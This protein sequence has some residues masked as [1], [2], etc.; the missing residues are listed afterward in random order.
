MLMNKEVNCSNFRGLLAYLR[1]HYGI[2][3]VQ[4]ATDGL[5][6]ND[7]YQVLNKENPSE[8]IR[9]QEHHLTD[10]AYWVSYEFTL[11]LFSNAK[12][13]LGGSNN[14][15]KA[16]EEATINH[17]SKSSFFL[18]RIFNAKF[19]CKQAPKLNAR[20]NRTK[21]VKLAELTNN[22]A[23]FEL[24]HYPNFTASK[25]ICNWNLGIYT[26]LAKITGVKEAKCEEIACAAEGADRC[27]FLLTWSKEPNLFKQLIRWILRK[28]SK[29]LI[30]DYEI[31]VNE[32]DQLIENLQQSEERYRALTDQSLTGIFIHHDG[33]LAYVNDC[34]S[35]MLEYSSTDM[36]GKRLWDFAHPD[37]RNL[38]K[39]NE[40]ARAKGVDRSLNYEFRAL[41]KSGGLLWLN[42][43]AT[44]VYYD[45]QKACMGNIIDQT[46]KKLAEEALYKARDE[47]EIH[48]Q[49][50]TAELLTANEQLRFEIEERRRAEEQTRASLREKEAL[51]REVH[52][53]VKNNFEI[54]SSLLGMS[55]ERNE[56]QE[57][58]RLLSDA[59]NRIYSMAIIHSQLYR[60]ER[61]D[62]IFMERYIRDLIDHLS[63][64]YT[65]NGRSISPIIYPSEV[66]LPINQAIPCALVLNEL[67]S[68][69]FKHAFNK[70]E[71]GTVWISID[72]SADK[73]VHL[74]VKD[75]G[76]GISE[77]L[78]LDKTTGI[79]LKLARNL[80][81]GQ[82]HGDFQVDGKNGTEIKVEFT[83]G[84]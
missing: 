10:S 77:D 70:G 12:Y 62:R 74:L 2:S 83:A 60:S 17:F 78:D 38:V 52:H 43:F 28:V 32:R 44:T 80:V 61:F 19:V 26:G 33:M 25:D 72:I 56:N 40:T 8:R 81:V 1:K 58:K 35:N 41:Q 37:D 23:K 18:S 51:L 16:G 3:G 76:R 64:V 53:R 55:D 54:I 20:F 31:M 9:I 21:T 15:I 57:T 6:N 7:R 68:N 24:C 75:N 49:H 73:T 82:L 47:L 29:D 59:R 36:I 63:S 13:I 71:N 48:V 14:L 42:I 22:S 30:T 46:S 66:R 4:Q 50:R 34:L 79:G 69:S 27:V 45:G 39:E 67:I 5:I 65:G 11:R 84:K